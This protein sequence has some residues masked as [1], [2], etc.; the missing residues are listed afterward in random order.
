MYLWV[1]VCMF[2]T[3]NQFIKIEIKNNVIFEKKTHL[4]YAEHKTNKDTL[5]IFQGV[6]MA[7]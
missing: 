1:N 4:K 3:K 2:K 5:D 6:V 7:R